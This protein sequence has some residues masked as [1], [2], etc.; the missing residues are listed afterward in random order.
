MSRKFSIIQKETDTACSSSFF[1]DS[2]QTNF[3]PTNQALQR[4]IRDKFAFFLFSEFLVINN[5]WHWIQQYNEKILCQDCWG[6][7]VSLFLKHC[8]ILISFKKTGCTS[9]FFSPKHHKKFE[10]IFFFSF[11]SKLTLSEKKLTFE[12]EKDS[13]SLKKFL[14]PLPIHQFSKNFKKKQIF[15]EKK[16][17]TIERFPQVFF[18]CVHILINCS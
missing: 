14:Y 8:K 7:S 6:N 9:V 5:F 12:E 1:S 10:H 16:E 3:S 13:K 4:M 15:H 18:S 11:T 2:W 17:R